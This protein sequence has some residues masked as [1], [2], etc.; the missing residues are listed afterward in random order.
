MIR[1]IDEKL[2]ELEAALQ[3]EQDAEKLSE[4]KKEVKAIL[5]QYFMVFLLLLKIIL[6]F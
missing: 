1:D 3:T 6:M 5:N 2:T 4:M